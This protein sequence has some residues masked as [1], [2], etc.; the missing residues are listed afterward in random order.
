M[1][2]LAF[3][4]VTIFAGFLACVLYVHYRGRV[5]LSFRRQLTDH[6][7]FLAPYNVLVYL[8]SRVPTTPMLDVAD[9]PA[10]APLRDHW[11][12]I[13]EEAMR[14]FEAGH[15]RASEHHDDLGFNTF[16]R[17]GWKRFYL[18]W[19]GEPPPSAK[20]LCP[21][22]VELVESIPSVHGAMFALIGPQS[23]VGEHRDPFAG[24]LR[25]HLGLITPNRDEC[26]I[27]VDGQPYSWRDGEDLVFD[28]TYVHRFENLTDETR[29]ILF[30]DLERPLRTPLMR[31]LNRFVIRH[32][33]G[34]T[35]TK[36]VDGERVGLANRAFGR[37]YG[38]RTPFR[39][40][41]KRNR[42]AYYAIKYAL[43]LVVVWLAVFGGYH[44]L[45]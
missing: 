14:L 6:S 25:Y 42:R 30:C 33:M 26:R 10:L 24:S 21:R 37:V 35:A 40:F 8:L 18:K 31:A 29:I 32:V 7:T 34:M 19:Y 12:E 11:R 38:L 45:R 16:F 2:A 1:S 20:A 15:I 3:S 36:N 44:A 43:I 9:F 5:R 28:E 13:R 41:K 4:R 23:R 17:K 39:R 22:T 27:F